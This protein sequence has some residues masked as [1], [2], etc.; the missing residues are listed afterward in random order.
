MRS[1]APST[2]DDLQR[3][4]DA[5]QAGDL[6][7]RDQLLEAAFDRLGR[8]ARKMRRSFAGV[9]G[10]GQ[11]D[12]VFQKA[13]MRLRKALA[14]VEL[15]SVDHFLHLAALQIRR[16][17]ITLA[18]VHS[19]SQTARPQPDDASDTS[20]DLEI[21]EESTYDPVRLARWSEFHEQVGKLPREQ[22]D[23]FDLLW[24]QGLSQVDAADRLGV[25]LRTLQRRWR[26]AKI[27]IHDALHGEMPG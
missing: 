20:K 12:D 27:S 24:Y 15:Q 14:E 21:P 5:V 11:T 19:R 1:P 2:S 22:R 17:L 13:L 26:E 4:V 8:L 18:R 23:V 6:T 7:A 3:L 9:P 16:E 10:R 25:P